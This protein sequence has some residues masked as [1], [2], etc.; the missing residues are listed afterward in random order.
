MDAVELNATDIAVWFSGVRA[1]EGV[2]LSLGKGEIVGL[3]GPNGAGKTTMVNVLSGFQR[4][5][6]GGVTIGADR[7]DGRSAAWFSRRGVVRTFQAVR[8]FRGLTVSENVEAALS[9]RNLGRT[10][11]RRR[12]GQI[13]DYMGI[14]D[15]AGLASDALTYGDE[16][17]VG[18]ARALALEP[19]FLLM[20]EPAAGL[21]IAEAAALGDVISRIRD[22]F[23]CGILL[24]EH[25]MTLI[26]QTCGR[27]HAMASGRTIATGLPDAVLA[28]RQVRAAYLGS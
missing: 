2:S 7:T 12:A 22:D 28:D 24:I 15:K 26:T 8:L 18:I 13:L 23:G 3:I 16:R 14:A 6:R 17:K 21:N 20:D 11:A 19:S 27:L 10:A 9:S 4:P 25:N 5:H 1:I